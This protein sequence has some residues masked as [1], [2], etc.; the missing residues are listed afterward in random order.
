MD[1]SGEEKGRVKSGGCGFAVSARSLS[2]AAWLLSLGIL[3]AVRRP[4]LY[5][6][7]IALW[8]LGLLYQLI[9]AAALGN[10]FDAETE[11]GPRRT[12]AV[13]W[14]VSFAVMLLNL[15]AAVYFREGLMWISAVLTPLCCIVCGI[16]TMHYGH[17]FSGAFVL[18]LSLVSWLSPLFMLYFVDFFS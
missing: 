12:L 9:V 6:E 17:F 8:G 4:S 10:A 3:I 15:L 1:H 11:R 16:G 14:C 13:L 2:V 5:A 7:A 18:A